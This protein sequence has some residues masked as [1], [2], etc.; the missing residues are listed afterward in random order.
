MS[1][2]F[3]ATFLLA[4]LLASAALVE[5]AALLR[6]EAVDAETQQPLQGLAQQDPI[7]DQDPSQHKAERLGAFL[8]RQTHCKR[9][10]SAQPW[11]SRDGMAAKA[12][13]ASSVLAGLR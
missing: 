1:P 10:T 4:A 13:W 3:L 9:A 7:Q 8:T 12:R 6:F 5:D 2:R 11:T